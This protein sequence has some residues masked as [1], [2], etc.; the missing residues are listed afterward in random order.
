MQQFSQGQFREALETFQSVLVIVR[1]IGERQVEGWTLNN[2][3]SV[4]RRLGQYPKA[5]ESYQP[6]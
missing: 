1:E 6:G 3:G 4:Y 5:L 2:L